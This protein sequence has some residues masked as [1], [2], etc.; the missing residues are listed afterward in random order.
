MLNALPSMDNLVKRGI[1]QQALCPFCHLADESLMHL[2]FYCPHVEPIWF[3]SALGLDPRQL[4]VGRFVEWWRY[5]K[6]VAKHMCFPSSVDHCAIICWQVWKVRNEKI[7]EHAEISPHKVLARI[8]CMIQEYST[9]NSSDLLGSPSRFRPIK[10]QNHSSCSRPPLGI[11]KVNTDA[12]FSPNLGIAALAMVGRNSNGD[13]CFRKTWI[14]MLLSP[15]TAGA[16]ALLKAVRF[17]EDMGLHDVIFESD[18]QVLVSCIQ[19]STKPV[20]WEAKFLM[21]IRQSCICHPDFRFTFVSRDGNRVADWVAHSSLRGRCP[22]YWAHRPPNILL[23][24]FLEDVNY[25]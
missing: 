6:N 18:N 7:F 3:G 11:F 12:S 21:S 13:I 23:T 4:A 19:Q 10:K 17:V 25:T 15:L 24:L 14:Y 8:Y 16:A 1:A 2:P 5:I 22:S 9:P 20:P